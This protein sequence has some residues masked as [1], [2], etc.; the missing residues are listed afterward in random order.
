MWLKT[1]KTMTTIDETLEARAQ[2]R[3]DVLR[4]LVRLRTQTPDEAEFGRLAAPMLDSMISD[5]AAV[6][7]HRKGGWSDE[8]RA[9]LREVYAAFGNDRA[10]E[11]AA[12]R[13]A[14]TKSQIRSMAANMGIK[15]P[16]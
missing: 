15:K 1:G 7:P 3:A 6:M 12:K 10:A 16:W 11:E 13:L 2:R 9:I 5:E 4:Q 14:R 8:E